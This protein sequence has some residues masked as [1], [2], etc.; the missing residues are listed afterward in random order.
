MTPISLDGG[1][2]ET[3][4]STA[5]Q[6]RGHPSRPVPQGLQVPF[7]AAEPCRAGRRG[8]KLEGGSWISGDEW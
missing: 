5:L 4:A 6:S 1:R 2:C 8:G 3:P 7:G